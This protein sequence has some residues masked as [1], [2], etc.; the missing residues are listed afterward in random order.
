MTTT[1]IHARAL[2]VWLQISTWSARRYDKTITRKVNAEYNASEDAGR[3]NKFLLPGDAESYKTLIALANSIRAKHYEQTLAWSDEGWRLLPTANYMQYAD[4]VRD[5]QREFTS[6]LDSFVRD[7]P[8]LKTQA[9]IKLNGLYKPEDYPDA[10]D[11]RSR[12]EVSITYA[13]VPA[14]G[15]IRVDLGADQIAA[16]ESSIQSRVQ[17]ATT[18]AVQDAWQRLHECV[19]HIVERLATPDG[20]FRDTLISNAR[21]LCD[22]LQRLNVTDDPN[23]EQMRRRVERELTTY[24]PDVL[25][26]T[27]HVREQV[28][29]QA[30]AILDQMSGLYKAV[31]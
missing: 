25:R 28:A 29:Q 16:I 12:F 7:Y 17:Q 5:R 20:I 8:Y 30:Q 2:L 14:E 1:N 18:I 26:D 10:Y 15:D 19:G 24:D 9:Q 23:L 31:A 4:W 27:P 13:P 6:A 11:I 21:K 22:V 3:Y